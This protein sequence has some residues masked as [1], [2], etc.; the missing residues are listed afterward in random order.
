M[1]RCAIPPWFDPTIALR[2]SCHGGVNT[3]ATTTAPWPPTAAQ[4]LTVEPLRW[5][6]QNRHEPRDVTQDP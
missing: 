1:R 6:R 5:V 4:P 2:E 3:I